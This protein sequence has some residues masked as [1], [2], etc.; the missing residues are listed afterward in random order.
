[1][2]GK[3][4]QIVPLDSFEVNGNINR[5]NVYDYFQESVSDSIFFNLKIN[6]EVT[7][8]EYLDF[9]I[10]YKQSVYDLRDEQ[11][12]MNKAL[13][14]YKINEREKYPFLFLEEIE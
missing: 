4:E 10:S 1:L 13:N 8:Q 9:M 5:Q 2:K 3:K 14:N 6:K 7:L 12:R 11:K